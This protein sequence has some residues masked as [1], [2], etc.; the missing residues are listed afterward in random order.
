MQKFH[1]V[2]ASITVKPETEIKFVE[3]EGLKVQNKLI[4]FTALTARWC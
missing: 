4:N 3:G 2:P 1:I